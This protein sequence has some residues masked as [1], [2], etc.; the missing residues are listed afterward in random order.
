[1]GPRI[2]SR[3]VVARPV[4]F[5]RRP[6]RAGEERS[7]WPSCAATAP[8]W[9]RT[10]RSRRIARRRPSCPSSI[11]GVT[12][13]AVLRPAA[14]RH[15][16]VRRLTAPRAVPANRQGTARSPAPS[17]P[18]PQPRGLDVPS[19]APVVERSRWPVTV[20][21]PKKPCGE[22]RETPSETP[23]RDRSPKRRRSPLVAV[24]VAAAVLLAGGGAAYWASTASGGG[25]TD[26]AAGRAG[27]APAAAGVGRLGARAARARRQSGIAPGEPD[28]HGGG[29]VYQADGPLPDGP[30]LGRRL[31]PER[32]RS[33]WPRWHGWPRP[34]G[35]A[36]R[37]GGRHAGSWAADG[38]ASGPVADG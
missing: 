37:R 7:A 21:Q 29:T 2:G 32:R 9:P 38:D 8:G 28:P 4:R 14:G 31:P 30:G 5:R 33:T 16:R 15:V 10:G 1:M 35:C 6:R 27:T 13:A 34:S 25:G 23:P 22:H 12:V 20:R 26:T 11:R 3:H 19:G 18:R 24:S 17:N 36:G